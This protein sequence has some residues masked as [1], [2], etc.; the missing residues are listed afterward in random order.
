M[1]RILACFAITA[2][3]FPLSAFSEAPKAIINGPTTG[4]AGELLVLDASKSAGKPTHYKWMVEPELPGRKM[5]EAECE[6]NSK[7]RICSIPGKYRYT[8][9]VS[10][11]DGADL[12][13]WDVAIPGTPPPLP[14]PPGPEPTPPAPTPPI[15]PTPPTP[16]PPEPPPTP[17]VVPDGR[18]GIAPKIVE[19]GELVKAESG[20]RKAEALKFAAS[21][22]AISSQVAAG[23]LT[24]AK[25]IVQALLQSN[26][27][28][29]GADAIA[30]RW[31]GFGLKLN[32]EIA[33]IYAT[34]K[35]GDRDAW[36][37]FLRECSVGFRAIK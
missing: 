26:R 22:E 3:G 1:S 8:L 15:P 14:S 25:S 20:E 9:V 2:V 37:V 32:A 4:I 31:T 17:D 21:F 36:A 23:G 30:K 27:L 33:Q 11:A 16:E 6:L 29:V 35:L 10:N 12:L 13:F 24:D 34:G 19:W 7:I 5:F 18:F 28:S